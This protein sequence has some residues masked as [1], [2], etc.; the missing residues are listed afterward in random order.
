VILHGRIYR[1]GE[2]DYWVQRLCC[3][4]W[5]WFLVGGIKLA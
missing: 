1:H 5:K 4:I 2:D 3:Q